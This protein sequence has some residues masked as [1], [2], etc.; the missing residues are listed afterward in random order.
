MRE[1][2]I[3]FSDL[4]EEAQKEYLEFIGEVDGSLDVFPIATIYLDE[5]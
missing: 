4:K 3:M 1:F 5:F 2:D